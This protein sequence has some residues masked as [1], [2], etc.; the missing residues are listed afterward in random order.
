MGHIISPLPL[1]PLLPA[2]GRR[3]PIGG[4]HSWASRNRNSRRR[5]REE[6]RMRRRRRKSNREEE[7]EEASISQQ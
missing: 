2:T 5:S 7:E 4:W 6:M 3:W 1:L